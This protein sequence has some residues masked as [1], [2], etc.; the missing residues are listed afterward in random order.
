MLCAWEM[1]PFEM[2]NWL[3]A[4]KSHTGTSANLLMASA[5]YASSLTQEPAR[6]EL[7]HIET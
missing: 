5:L 4:F 3:C 6:W 2:Q 7:A 1:E